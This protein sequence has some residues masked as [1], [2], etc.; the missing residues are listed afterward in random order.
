MVTPSAIAGSQCSPRVRD[1]MVPV[2]AQQPMPRKSTTTRARVA[3]FELRS[4]TYAKAAEV[5][6]PTQY[7]PSVSAIGSPA[8]SSTSRIMPPPMLQTTASS[9]KPTMS[10]RR[11]R[12]TAPPSRPLATTAA[13]STTRNSVSGSMVLSTV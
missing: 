6:A 13:I 7:Q 8:F 2:A 5:M 3:Q 9:K 11:A 4:S 12:A 1:L 10:N